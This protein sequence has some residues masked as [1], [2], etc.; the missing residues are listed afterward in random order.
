MRYELVQTKR[1]TQPIHR[2]C[3]ALCVSKSGYYACRN[4]SDSRR[5]CEDRRLLVEIRASFEASKRT[6]GSPRVTKDLKGLGYR[7]SAKRVA[8]IMRQNGLTALLKKRFRSTTDSHHGLPIFQ[9]VLQ[10]RFSASEPDKVWAGDVTYI[11]TEEGGLYLAVLMDLYSRRIVGWKTAERND[12]YLALGALERAVATRRPGTGLL[13][14]TDR[15]SP[16]A[17]YEYQEKLA[18]MSAV[19]SMSRKGDCYD[20]AVVESFF[21]S[22]KR[23]RVH[24]RK[25]WSRDEA[26]DDLTEYI[27]FY[28]HSRRHSHTGG[29]SPD[30]FEKCH[31]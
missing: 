12:R 1:G 18:Q 15:G 3:A 22:L 29:I 26:R 28:N 24:R 21:G 9:N 6:Y 27:N 31:V 20:N 16:Y 8:R 5:A 11:T 4:R 23:E 14:H 19:C 13:H 2:A 25:Y 10:R 30:E 7:C 17:A